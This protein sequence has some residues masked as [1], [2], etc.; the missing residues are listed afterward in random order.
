MAIA[1]GAAGTAVVAAD[2]EV[3]VEA[4]GVAVVMAAEVVAM[5]AEVVDMEA[6]ARVTAGI[7]AIN[8]TFMLG[9]LLSV[10]MC[11]PYVPGRPRCIW[12]EH[13]VFTLSCTAFLLA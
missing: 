5:A 10:S 3:A 4:I 13:W 2:I 1:A 7:S 12:A 8:A 11:S 9:R 6:A